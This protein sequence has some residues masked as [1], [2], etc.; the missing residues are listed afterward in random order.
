MCNSWKNLETIL[1]FAITANVRNQSCSF[2]PTV[3]PAIRPLIVLWAFSSLYKAT[4]PPSLPVES[5]PVR[6]VI[7]SSHCTHQAPLHACSLQPQP[8]RSPTTLPSP[9]PPRSPTLSPG[10][11]TSISEPQTTLLAT[12]VNPEESDPPIAMNHLGSRLI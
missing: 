8:H 9:H 4:Y 5:Y 11:S 6:I 1:F 10:S 3:H 12:P 2:S 7:C